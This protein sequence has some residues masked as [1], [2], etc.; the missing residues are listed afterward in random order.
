ML[1][2]TAALI[3]LYGIFYTEEYR[4]L[5]RLSASYAYV[6]V[7]KPSSGHS[8]YDGSKGGRRET[9]LLL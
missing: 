1:I 5:L 4:G 6:E 2:K 9:L 7:T 3:D 8:N